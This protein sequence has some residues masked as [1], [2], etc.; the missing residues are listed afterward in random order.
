MEE[1]DAKFLICD[2]S[3]LARKNLSAMLR[4][5]GYTNILEVSNGQDAVNAY[6]HEH[7]TVV[8]LDI[9]MP[10]KDGIT[11]TKEIMAYDPKA[12]VIMVSSVGT[13][14]NL[15]EAIKAGA[16]DF[17]QKPVEESLLS[18]VLEHVMA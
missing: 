9:V 6:M 16:R 2:D 7:P 8:L 18:Q 1:K 3:I 5:F 4:S 15:R 17:I 10:I 14:T 11:A 12:K 13:Q